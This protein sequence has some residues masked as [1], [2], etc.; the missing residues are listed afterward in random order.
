MKQIPNRIRRVAALLIAVVLAAIGIPALLAG[1]DNNRTIGTV[2]RISVVS[3]YKQSYQLDEPL[4]KSGYLLAD[5]SKGQVRV[6]MTDATF[7]GFDSGITGARTMTITYGGATTTWNY[8]VAYSLPIETHTR[9]VA[10]VENG[11]LSVRV[12]GLDIALYAIA[13]VL[14]MPRGE[15][16]PVFAPHENFTVHEQRYYGGWNVV[17]VATRPITENTEVLRA[18][19]QISSARV[20]SVKLSD[21]VR[22]YQAPDY[23]PQG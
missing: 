21:S 17:L 15:E 11:A 5:T 22:D 18:V 12:T 13:F 10:S 14:D 9:V 4:D 1:C 20:E 6:P 7:S 23:I 8:T 2:S 16:P 3:G 19:G